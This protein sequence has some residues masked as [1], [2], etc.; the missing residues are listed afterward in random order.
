MTFALSFWTRERESEVVWEGWLISSS[1]RGRWRPLARIIVFAPSHPLSS[2][3]VPL[4][5]F[6]PTTSKKPYS[7]AWK[8]DRAKYQNIVKKLHTTCTMARI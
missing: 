7:V 8:R 1:R 4:S 3:S 6:P 5:I 2:L